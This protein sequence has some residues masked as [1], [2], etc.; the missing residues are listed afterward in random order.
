VQTQDFVQADLMFEEQYAYF[1]STSKSWLQHA[2]N[3]TEDIVNRLKL[4][5]IV[6]S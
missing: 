3:Y 1:S 2:E 5:K 6:L 4:N